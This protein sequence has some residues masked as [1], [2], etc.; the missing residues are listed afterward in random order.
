MRNLFFNPMDNKEKSAR[1]KMIRGRIAKMLFGMIECN[2]CLISAA[3]IAFED[4]RYRRHGATFREYLCP[5]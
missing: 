3:C 5:H 4:Y 1:K 2:A